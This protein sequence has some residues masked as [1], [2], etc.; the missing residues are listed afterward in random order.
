MKGDGTVPYLSASI[1]EQLNSFSFERVLPYAT[2]HGGVVKEAKC[3]E[4]IVSKLNQ[5][6]SN[7]SGSNMLYDGYIVVRIACPVDVSISD[8]NGSELNSSAENFMRVS[9]FGRLDIIGLSND[10]KMACI[11][12]SPNF[13]II[14][15]G[16]DIGTMDYDIRYFNGNDELYKEDSFRNIPITANTVIK[17]GTD[18]TKTTVLDIDNNRLLPCA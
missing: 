14:L 4:W 6:T 7:I 1:S 11:N 2:D 8:S 10:I 9:S 18:S 17:T 16:T 12:D 13:S 3:L 15:N 5:Q